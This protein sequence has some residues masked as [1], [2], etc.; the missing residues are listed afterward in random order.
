M[1]VFWLLQQFVIILSVFFKMILISRMLPT[2][3][4]SH[5][6]HFTFIIHTYVY[7]NKQYDF[8][9]V[10]SMKIFKIPWSLFIENYRV[11]RFTSFLTNV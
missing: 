8:Q 1:D 10:N 9:F 3:D 5:S 11:I 7:L 4:N 2:L 6:S